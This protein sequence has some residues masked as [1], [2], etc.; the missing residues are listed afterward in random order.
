MTSV[1][2]DAALYAIGRRKMVERQVAA[3]GVA[4]ARVLEAMREIPREI[5]VEE[6]LRGQAFAD[7]ALPIGHGQTI[8]QPYIA[9]RM[10][11][12]LAPARTG[13][14]L[15]IGTGTGYQTALLARLAT[16]VLSIERIPALA[17]KAAT[18]LRAL[19]FDNVEIRVGDGSL[20]WPERAPFDG[21]LVAAAA[22]GVPASL[23]AQ[24]APGGRLIVPVGDRRAQVLTVVT[25]T[26]EGIT[27]RRE[28]G[29][30]FVRLVGAG[31]WPDET[32]AP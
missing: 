29:C 25:R 10:T 13:R 21:I 30:V 4:D 14:I 22:P 28:D 12:L 3:R 15:E 23:A 5:F 7:S 27:T 20:G 16:S 24:L 31:G 17:E 32:G 6:A 11:E 18:N 19:G 1:A 9:A 8:S 26:D 2:D